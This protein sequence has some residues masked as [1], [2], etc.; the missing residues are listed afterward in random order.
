MMSMWNNPFVQGIVEDMVF[1]QA[2]GD[3]V[4]ISTCSKYRHDEWPNIE[5]S[6]YPKYRHSVGRLPERNS[7]SIGVPFSPP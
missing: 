3:S 2:H 4:F 7:L 6:V 1:E 5:G